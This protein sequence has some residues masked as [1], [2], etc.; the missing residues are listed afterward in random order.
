MRACNSAARA[1]I[2]N[3][4]LHSISHLSETVQHEITFKLDQDYRRS[5]I[6]SNCCH[7]MRMLT[8]SL[9]NSSMLTHGEL[10]VRF[11]NRLEKDL[12]SDI[13]FYLSSLYGFLFI[14]Y[15]K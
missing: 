15:L 8:S 11:L 2:K 6:L 1:D 7:K 5:R 3:L 14:K 4:A 13:Y 10:K 12:S 9:I